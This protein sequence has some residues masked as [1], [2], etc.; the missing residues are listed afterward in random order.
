M[1]IIAEENVSSAVK[2]ASMS[3]IT[4]KYNSYLVL[5]SIL[6]VYMLI[7]TALLQSKYRWNGTFFF[8]LLCSIVF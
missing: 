4:G 8:F 2:S 6:V 7:V 5:Q 1:A 3:S